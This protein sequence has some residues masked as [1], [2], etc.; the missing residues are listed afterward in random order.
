MAASLLSLL[1]TDSGTSLAPYGRLALILDLCPKSWA[2]FF[3]EQSTHASGDALSISVILDL[4]CA[5]A[6]QYYMIN[7]N[8]R[9]SL[10]TMSP[11]RYVS[12]LT[13]G[14][15]FLRSNTDS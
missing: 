15:E 6:H 12:E 13:L 4:V 3:E 9:I 2:S 11:E 7:R 5:Y 10:L 14:P 1:M 8:N